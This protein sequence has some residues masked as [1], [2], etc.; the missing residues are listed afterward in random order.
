MLAD[1]EAPLQR[2]HRRLHRDAQD[3]N[4]AAESQNQDDAE[5]AEGLDLAG[6][7]DQLGL[8]EALDERVVRGDSVEHAAFS[9]VLG[10]HGEFQRALLKPGEGRLEPLGKLDD[11][12]IVG[13][14]T[15]N[16]L[17]DRFRGCLID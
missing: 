17:K 3:Q 2:T 12:L 7:A 16:V 15:L 6:A 5:H 4:Q 10:P 14:G 8:A 11:P 13:D 9:E 1:A